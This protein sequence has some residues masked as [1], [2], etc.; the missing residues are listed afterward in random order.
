MPKKGRRSQA[1]QARETHQTVR[2]LRQQHRAIESDINALEHHGLNCGPDKWWAGFSARSGWESW[3]TI[4]TRLATGCWNT[5]D[6]ASRNSNKPP[7]AASRRKESCNCGKPL[8]QIDGDV[9][10][11]APLQDRTRLVDKK[12]RS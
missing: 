11:R 7:S 6:A 12:S 2:R 10:G 3:R 4:S 8:S 5:T 1:D 9:L